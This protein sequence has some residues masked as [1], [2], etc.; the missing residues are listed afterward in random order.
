MQDR[1]A[2]HVGQSQKTGDAEEAKKV[3]EEATFTVDESKLGK[4]PADLL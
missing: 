3:G 1:A 4:K 2:E